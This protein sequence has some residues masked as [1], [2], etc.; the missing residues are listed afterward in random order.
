MCNPYP[1][2]I[3]T[4]DLRISIHSFHF[5]SSLVSISLSTMLPEWDM[6]GRVSAEVVVLGGDFN[7][8]VHNAHRGVQQADGIYWRYVK[9]PIRDDC[10]DVY[11]IFTRPLESEEAPPD[12]P[13]PP[14]RK[15]GAEDEP[16]DTENE[17]TDDEDDTTDTDDE[18]TDTDDELNPIDLIAHKWNA[19]RD[20]P[21]HVAKRNT[22]RTVAEWCPFETDFYHPDSIIQILLNPP[23]T[24]TRY[25]TSYSPEQSDKSIYLYLMT[26]ACKLLDVPRMTIVCETKGNTQGVSRKMNEVGDAIKDAVDHHLS[27]EERVEMVE[28]KAM[29]GV[30]REWAHIEVSDFLQKCIVVPGT[31]EPALKC[32]A[33]A[34]LR[35]G[36]R[37][38]IFVDEGDKLAKDFFKM[39]APNLTKVQKSIK[40]LYTSAVAVNF[41]TATPVAILMNL[42]ANG[43]FVRGFIADFERIKE[44][45]YEIGDTIAQHPSARGLKNKD[46]EKHSGWFHPV[47]REVIEEI[48]DL[49]QD[50]TEA[51]MKNIL[52]Q[53]VMNHLHNPSD[54]LFTNCDMARQLVHGT[55]G[56]SGWCPNAF[57]VVV[58]G[59]HVFVAY[60]ELSGVPATTK[61][62]YSRTTNRLDRKL[63]CPPTF[64][65]PTILIPSR[66]TPIRDTIS[67]TDVT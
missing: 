17:L 13:Y 66:R 2:H 16:T 20:I 58:S 49:S 52:A 24:G 48:H 7:F 37:P 5:H 54:V 40:S 55:T 42:R 22:T 12:T 23:S 34:V 59:D 15:G 30:A 1:L 57:G 64:T 32:A 47:I 53:V 25:S 65:R 27:A 11:T 33:D 10:D 39:D 44:N 61:G 18:Q 45:G 50:R 60:S 35:L 46:F 43:Q 29:T 26:I 56:T 19:L 14:T 51:G 28:M 3:F 21:V 8:F 4:P 67:N 36:I 9:G 41:V 62:T 38:I 63:R 31:Y 6:S